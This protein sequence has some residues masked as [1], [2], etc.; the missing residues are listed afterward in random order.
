M[1]SF[2]YET[3]IHSLKNHDIHVITLHGFVSSP[4]KNSHDQ[5]GNIDWKHMYISF[6]SSYRSIVPSFHRSIYLSIYLTTYQP[7]Q[8]SSYLPIY[9]PIYLPSYLYSYL[10]IHWSIYLPAY[11][12]IYLPTY[13][14]TYYL[15]TYSMA[16]SG[17]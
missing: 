5:Y 16:M 15:A 4:G 17:T 13:L 12:P 8:L 1:V 9:Q 7:I 11:R 14:S 10:P 2:N 6:L 3:L